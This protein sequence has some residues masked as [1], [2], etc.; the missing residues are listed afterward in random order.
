MLKPLL[1]LSW[2]VCASAQQVQV[3]E[4]VLDNGLK[5]LLVPRKGSPNVNAGWVA[6]VGS[7]NERPGIT[8]ISHLFEHM[9]FKGTHTIGTRN[10]E[11]DLKLNVEL[12]RV[13]GE[14]RKEEQELARRL[15]EGEIT[16]VKDPKV[17]TP[18]HQQLIDEFE[19]LSKRE[20]ELIVKEELDRIYTA[21]GATGVNAGTSEDW[22]IYFA[23]I[24]SNKLELWYWMESDRLLHP[25]F[26]EFY[27]ER[28]VVH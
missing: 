6:K 4:F 28:D 15:R 18:R 9:M 10:I 11:E 3:Q 5:L 24:P 14:M 19:R 22:T 17:R 23:N 1:L 8:G 16:D 12:D 2:I 21:A 25:V 26:R 13:K 27:S 20:K 7:V